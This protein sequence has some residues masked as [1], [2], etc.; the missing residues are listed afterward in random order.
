MLVERMGDRLAAAGSGQ[1]I[2]PGSVV[3]EG[4]ADDPLTRV[5]GSSRSE[6]GKVMDSGRG[7]AGVDVAGD[8]VDDILRTSGEKRKD[9][10]TKTFRR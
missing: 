4:G 9:K 2:G 7:V 3:G 8:G 10:Q 1:E 5:E 6:E